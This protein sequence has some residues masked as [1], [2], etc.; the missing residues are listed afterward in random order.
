MSDGQAWAAE[1]M[2][3]TSKRKENDMASKMV[4]RFEDAAGDWYSIFLFNGELRLSR[5][6]TGYLNMPF[7]TPANARALL[8][9]L[10]EFAGVE[11]PSELPSELPA[12]PVGT[13]HEQTSE[14]VDKLAGEVASCRTETAA[15]SQEVARLEQRVEKLAEALH[16]MLYSESEMERAREALREA[17]HPT[18]D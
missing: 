11:L 16:Y 1:T 14:R 18:E 5:N 6:G 3:L 12:E 2:F 15:N 9:I 10:T 4:L 13:L 8:P 17:Q 7:L